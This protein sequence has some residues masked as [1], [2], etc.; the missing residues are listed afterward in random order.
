MDTFLLIMATV[1][2]KTVIGRVGLI[3]GLSSIASFM[4]NTKSLNL[5]YYRC[6]ALVPKLGD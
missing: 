2:L 1:R 5:E 6:E 3:S 4:S